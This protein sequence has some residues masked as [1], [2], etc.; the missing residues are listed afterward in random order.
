MI[1]LDGGQIVLALLAFL[2]LVG[3]LI[4][5]YAAMCTTDKARDIA[6]GWALALVLVALMSSIAAETWGEDWSRTWHARAELSRQGHHVV[7]INGVYGGDVTV[8]VDGCDVRLRWARQ[9]P[10]TRVGIYRR[11]RSVPLSRVQVRDVAE[12]VCP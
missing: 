1:R 7:A 2:A 8:R 6:I 3:A 11:G 5:V 10:R 4:A 9:W 12:T